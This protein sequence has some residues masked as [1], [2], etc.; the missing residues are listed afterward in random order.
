MVP[1]FKLF[2]DNG[3]GFLYS[4]TMTNDFST[5]SAESNLRDEITVRSDEYDPV[6]NPTDDDTT[7]DAG[8]PGD[9]SGTDDFADYNA[10]EV[11]DYRDE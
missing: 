7:V 11:D 4:N 3:D 1:G 8:W 9:G 5:I 10:N 2:V 6:A